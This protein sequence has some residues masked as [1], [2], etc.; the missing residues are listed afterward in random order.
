MPS[1]FFKWTGVGIVFGTISV[2]AFATLPP[3]RREDGAGI[4]RLA[5]P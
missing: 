1:G 5:S 2:P 3:D 4:D